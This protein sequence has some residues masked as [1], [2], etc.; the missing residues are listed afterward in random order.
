M[1]ESVCCE[2]Q[3]IKHQKNG[4][5]CQ[6]KTFELFQNGVHVIALADGAGSASHSHFGAECVVRTISHL[7]VK[8][9]QD[10]IACDDGRKV[11]EEI[12]RELRQQLE[13]EAQNRKCLLKDLAST[14]LFVAIRE[15]QFIIAHIGDGVIGYLEGKSELKVAS[16]PDNGEFANITTFVTSNEA[17]ISMR[18]FKGTINNKN[19]FVLM[20]DGTEQSFYNKQTNKLANVIVKLMYKTCSLDKKD[21]KAQLEDSFN[22][23]IIKKTQDDCSIAIL[24]RLLSPLCPIEDLPFG[25][26][27]DLYGLN[28][29]RHVSR[30]RIKNYDSLISYLQEPHDFSSIVKKFRWGKNRLRKKYI[31]NLLVHL[32]S[33]KLIKKEEI[34]KKIFYLRNSFESIKILKEKR[35]LVEHKGENE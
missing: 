13:E 3:G 28:K 16:S 32:L 35:D 24:A 26:K 34:G 33:R 9:F 8:H 6:D 29:V 1:W 4:I 15:D 18:L 22:S 25:K 12:I 20:S 31:K 11:K 19:A 27:L 14:M 10:Y 2:V 21:I 17:T 7:M 30:R 5:P 23:I